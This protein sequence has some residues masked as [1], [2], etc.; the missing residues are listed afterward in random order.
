MSDLAL[1][2][3]PD[4][5]LEATG[6]RYRQPRRLPVGSSATIFGDAS[7]QSSRLVMCDAWPRQLTEPSTGHIT[8]VHSRAGGMV[9]KTLEIRDADWST[10]NTS[11]RFDV[12]ADEPSL[13]VGSGPLSF[14]AVVTAL[15]TTSTLVYRSALSRRLG[16][17]LEDFTACN[18]YASAVS[19]RDLMRFLHQHPGWPMPH[20][21][22]TDDGLLQARWFVDNDHH[23]AIEFHRNLSTRIAVYAIVGSQFRESSGFDNATRVLPAFEVDRWIGRARSPAAV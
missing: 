21:Y 20:V 7:T 16:E 12:V 17:I 2:I 4:P 8:I 5:A 3:D 13:A 23:L 6:G 18:I 11:I 10:A 14:E 1:A 9:S 19:A 22:G 15:T